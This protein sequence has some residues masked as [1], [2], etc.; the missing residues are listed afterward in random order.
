MAISGIEYYEALTSENSINPL[1]RTS[2]EL[3]KMRGHKI[4]RCAMGNEQ[5]SIGANGNVYPCHLLHVKEFF[6]G[7]IR[8]K[9]I[10]EI[11]NHS[12]I[13]VRIREL[14]VDNVSGCNSCDFRYMC[15][16]GCRGRA[17]WDSGSVYKAG[18]FCDYEI[19]AILDGLFKSCGTISEQ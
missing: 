19:N 1:G 5:I 2:I 10:A 11:Y 8:E 14:T 13:L 9:S 15:G 16:G 17:Y 4:R 7:N 3:N 12:P 6:S 18:N